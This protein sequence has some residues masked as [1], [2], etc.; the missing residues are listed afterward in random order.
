MEGGRV[1]PEWIWQA[2]SMAAAAGGIYAGIRA[3]LAAIRAR[4]EHAAQ[5]ADMAHRRLD[6]YIGAG[7]RGRGRA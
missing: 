3:D 7:G 2:V 1:V 5:S 6:D 4:A